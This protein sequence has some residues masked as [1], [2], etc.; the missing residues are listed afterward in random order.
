MRRVP[1]V[2]LFAAAWLL[3]GAAPGTAALRLADVRGHLAIGFA[4]VSSSDTSAT[5]SGSLSIGGG[6]DLPVRPGLR[7]G[8]GVGYHLLGSRTL[9]Q[10]T[11]TSGLDYSL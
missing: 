9:V 8:V 4:H 7:A 10:G 2:A 5:P 11:L 6:A 1:I 3:G